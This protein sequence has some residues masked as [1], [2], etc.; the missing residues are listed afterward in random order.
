M[1]TQ[2]TLP[3][4]LEPQWRAKIERQLGLTLASVHWQL[5]RLELVFDRDDAKPAAVSGDTVY[6]CRLE[7]RLRSGRLVTFAVK[8]RDL[9]ACTA[10]IAARLRREI[11]RDK[12][13]GL[14]GRVG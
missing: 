3:P 2:L 1:V 8:N 14:L 11:N 12:Q 13:L 9:Q 4:A 5:K 10:D 6:I 7:A